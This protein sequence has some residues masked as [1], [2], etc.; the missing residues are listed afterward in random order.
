MNPEQDNI[1]M[2]LTRLER[3][4]EAKLLPE[5]L[6]ITESAELLRCSKS[7]I[8][9]LLK[10]GELNFTRIGSSIK[11]NILIRRKDIMKLVK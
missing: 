5:Y 9:L 4:L 3:L 10:D 1:Q 7:K 6:T 8:R 2:Q 11:S